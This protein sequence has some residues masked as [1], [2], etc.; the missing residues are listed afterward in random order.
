MDKISVIR[1]ACKI[2]N[3]IRGKITHANPLLEQ[4]QYAFDEFEKDLVEPLLEFEDV[5]RAANLPKYIEDVMPLVK[6]GIKEL[7]DV[8][9][10]TALIVRM[11]MTYPALLDVALDSLALT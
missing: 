6:P 3:R 5:K 2:F 11:A 1:D 7:S 8:V 4:E 10:K 9:G